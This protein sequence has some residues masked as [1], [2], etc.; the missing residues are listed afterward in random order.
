MARTYSIEDDFAVEPAAWRVASPSPKPVRLD[1]FDDEDDDD[2][3][4]KRVS[5]GL[6]VLRRAQR[7]KASPE[8]KALEK[9]LRACGAAVSVI[10]QATR[11][12]V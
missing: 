8:N 2:A 11:V 5:A 6:S 7:R 4:L 12:A 10:S 3:A 9:K 1:A